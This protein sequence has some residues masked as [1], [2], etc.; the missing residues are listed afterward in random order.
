MGQVPSLLCVG[1]GRG[2]G[3]HSQIHTHESQ[4]KERAFRQ[5]HHD[6][7]CE[8]AKVGEAPE[9]EDAPILSIPATRANP[10]AQ[11]RGL[12]REKNTREGSALLD[13]SWTVRA[14]VCVRVCA[15]VLKAGAERGAQ[16]VEAAAQLAVLH[17]SECPLYPALRTLATQ[18]RRGER[19]P[20]H[21]QLLVKDEKQMN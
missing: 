20:S 1:G 19:R 2:G 16:S 12:P 21:W 18:Q 3:S 11:L 17:Q 13:C 10:R 7:R 6:Q 9:A 5:V 15:S 14:S 4:S 8:R